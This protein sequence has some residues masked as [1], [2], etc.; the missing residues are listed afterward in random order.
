M[1]LL[2][3]TLGW[4]GFVA[5]CLAL[6]PHAQAVPLAQAAALD[7]GNQPVAAGAITVASVTATQ[8][9]FVA[10][11][12]DTAGSPGDLLGATPVKKGTN[13][14]VK[15]AIKGDVPNGTKVWVRLHIDAGTLGTLEFPGADVPARGADGNAVQKQ[16]VI[17]PAAAPAA[18]T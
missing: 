5:L 7:I 3:R 8:D 10:A 2:L 14:G 12:R 17:Q 11:F 13:A 15:I 9:G 18:A 4:A 1:S 16:L 6:A